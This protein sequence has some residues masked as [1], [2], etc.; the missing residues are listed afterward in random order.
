MAG[1]QRTYTI[2]TEHKRTFMHDSW[3][4]TAIWGWTEGGERVGLGGGGQ[5]E[6]KWT[7]VIV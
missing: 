6:K 3:T 7:T 2:P 1:K 5:R 4:Q